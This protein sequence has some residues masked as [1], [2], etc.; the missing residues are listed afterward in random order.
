VVEGPSGEADLSR[1]R[2]EIESGTVSA[3][4]VLDP[5]PAGSAGDLKW[6]A[7]A[8]AAGKIRVLVVE[9]VV[10]SDLS[11]A[12]DIV[13]PGASYLEKDACYTN[14]FGHVQPAAQA[15]APPGDAMEDWQI[16]VNVGVTLG[17]DLSYTSSSHVRADIAAAMSDR[18]G[19]A[20]I[21]RIVFAR[22]TVAAN[23]LQTSNPSERWKWDTLFK[24]LPPV[25]FKGSA[26]PSSRRD[27]DPDAIQERK[28]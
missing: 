25:K 11:R 4:Y 13:L 15:V 14:D 10:A 24:D 21:T 2:H 6:L 17:V 5:G 26:E 22:Q 7:E 20:D 23:W 3:V 12:A 28:P 16:L 9:A 1:L 18:P 19:Y 27:L 8:R